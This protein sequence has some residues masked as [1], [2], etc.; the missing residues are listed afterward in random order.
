M[1]LYEIKI[2]ADFQK[3]ADNYREDGKPWCV[4]TVV[5]FFLCVYPFFLNIIFIELCS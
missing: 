5:D 1:C 4:V 2:E 3:L